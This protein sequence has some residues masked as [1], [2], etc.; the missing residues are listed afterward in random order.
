MAHS[1]QSTDG[2]CRPGKGSF[3]LPLQP[4]SPHFAAIWPFLFVIIFSIRIDQSDSVTMKL[5]P[6]GVGVILFIRNYAFR[7]FSRST[8]PFTRNFDRLQRCFQ[9]F[10][11]RRTGRVQVVSKRNT[12]AVDTT[13]HF[14]PL[15]RLVLTTDGPLFSPGHS[16]HQRRI[17][18][19]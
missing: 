13:I 18:L 3:H 10:H 6:Q 17:S 4:I 5:I 15:T 1:S 19:R 9:Q 16:C 2:S 11:F 12:L 8:S 7:L 14:V